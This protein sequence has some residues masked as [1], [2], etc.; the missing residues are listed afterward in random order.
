MNNKSNE[1]P[2]IFIG[3]GELDSNQ[4]DK[5]EECYLWFKQA[6]MPQ[7]RKDIM[8][9][10]PYPLA[11]FFQWSD[12]FLQFGSGGDTYDID[13]MSKYASKEL[14]DALEGAVKKK[15]EFWE[16][17]EFR[18]MYQQAADLFSADLE[19]WI[20]ETDKIAPV[21]FFIGPNRANQ[22]DPWN[23]W[24]HEHLADAFSYI[25]EFSRVNDEILTIEYPP[26]ED[27]A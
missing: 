3:H 4:L 21:A 1:F 16:S 23:K 26:T 25:N 20:M 24:S 18:K 27:E 7:E 2:F 17:K 22:N 11:G 5:N 10:C 15:P 8:K 14:N 13:I 9:S 19:R 6:V 12:Y